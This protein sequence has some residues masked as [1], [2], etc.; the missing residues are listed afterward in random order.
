MTSAVHTDYCRDLIPKHRLFTVLD[1]WVDGLMWMEGVP[2]GS[3]PIRVSLELC[4]PYCLSRTLS[5]LVLLREFVPS[6]P[7]KIP[8]SMSS[9]TEQKL[10]Q[11][12][13]SSVLSRTAV[14]GAW[15]DLFVGRI[16]LFADAMWRW[17]L[18][19][20]WPDRSLKDSKLWN[21]LRLHSRLPS[22]ILL[23]R[24]L[25]DSSDFVFGDRDSSQ[26]SSKLLGSSQ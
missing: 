11:T 6:T 13:E 19:L 26:V 12:Q 23:M 24:L 22:A 25:P 15:F 21:F 17:L 7:P 20:S 1:P 14:L 18:F 16:E 2:G 10:E 3:S 8:E 5:V 4:L 9:D